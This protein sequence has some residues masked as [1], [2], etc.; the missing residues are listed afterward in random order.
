MIGWLSIENSETMTG[1]FPVTI[2]MQ[3]A[4]ID[5]KSEVT[6]NF[7][8]GDGYRVQMYVHPRGNND[9]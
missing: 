7:T 9:R 3:G 1:T 2:V 6:G 8:Y 4:R 5:A